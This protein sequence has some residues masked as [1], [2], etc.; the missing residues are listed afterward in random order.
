MKSVGHSIK[1]VSKAPIASPLLAGI[2]YAAI[3]LAL[4]A[5]T[6]SVLLKWGSLQEDQLPSSSLIVHGLAALAGGF[7]A[8]RRSGRKG[9]YYGAFLGFAYGL[10]VLL[11]GFLASDAAFNTR[12]LTMIGIALA[13]GAFG[14]M[15]GVNTKRS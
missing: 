12:I 2:L 14:G 4:G 15:I 3:W 1:D 6:L 13:S 9:W 10:L 11:V 8:G 5:L 7:V